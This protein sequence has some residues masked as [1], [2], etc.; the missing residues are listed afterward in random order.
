MTVFKPTMDWKWVWG[1]KQGILFFQPPQK[2]N[3]RMNR[4]RV[5]C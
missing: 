3:Y 5:V 1:K 2:P 4:Q